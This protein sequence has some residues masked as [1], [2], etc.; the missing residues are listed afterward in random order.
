M[1]EYTARDPWGIAAAPPTLPPPGFSTAGA[2]QAIGQQWSFSK[3]INPRSYGQPE[4][5]SDLQIPGGASAFS[6]SGGGGS[7]G[8]MAAPGR[9]G[10]GGDNG[11]PSADDVK[12]YFAD[13]IPERAGGQEGGPAEGMIPIG[14]AGPISGGGPG[15]DGGGGRAF[16]VLPGGLS[17]QQFAAHAAEAGPA[18][19]AAGG[20]LSV[21]GK[22]AGKLL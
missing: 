11:S 5:T 6:G 4:A 2:T 17:G 21:L 16:T 19:E 20:V 15:L 12:Q 14:P 13:R 22:T 1:P 18:A 10:G 8:G 9:S 3:Q 7:V